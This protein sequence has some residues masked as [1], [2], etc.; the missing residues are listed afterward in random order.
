MKLNKST[1]FSIFFLLCFLA[2]FSTNT[3]RSFN[4]Y[5]SNSNFKVSKAVT[6]SSKEEKG[7]SSNDFLFEEN[8]NEAE[9]S[10]LMPAFLLPFFV[11]Y[12]QNNETKHQS[13][14]TYSLS[15]NFTNPIYIA[16]CNFRI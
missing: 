11:T 16:V 1:Y 3:F 4:S 6:F 7:S 13:L 8:E 12:F 15:E 9:N 5:S 10:F 2:S 14:L